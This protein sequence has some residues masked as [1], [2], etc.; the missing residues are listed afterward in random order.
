MSFFLIFDLTIRLADGSGIERHGQLGFVTGRQTG[1]I[2]EWPSFLV[3][4]ILVRMSTL[5]YLARQKKCFNTPH[6]SLLS[7]LPGPLSWQWADFRRT[8]W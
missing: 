7:P 5:Y 8:G 4:V 2:E 3:S 1:I 6:G